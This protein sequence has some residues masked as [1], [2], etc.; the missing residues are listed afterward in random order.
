[1]RP[2]V[3]RTSAIAASTAA[4]AV[5]SQRRWATPSSVAMADLIK[6]AAN[7]DGGVHFEPPKFPK[8]ALAL[9]YDEVCTAFGQANSRWVLKQVCYIVVTGLLPLVEAIQSRDTP[10]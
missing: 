7:A 5:M 9:D 3:A 8:E 6:A 4:A 10:R 2:C 1:M